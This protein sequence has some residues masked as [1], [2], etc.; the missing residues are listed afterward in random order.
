MKMQEL[1]INEMQQINGGL[2]GLFGNDSSSAL[3]GLLEGY[4]GI[5]TVDEDGDTNSTKINFG[6]GSMFGSSSSEE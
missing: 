4:I 2:L 1:N 6:L 3:S 5:T